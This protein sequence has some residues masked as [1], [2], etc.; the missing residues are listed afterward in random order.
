MRPSFSR[1]ALPLLFALSTAQAA[2]KA[3]LWPRWQAHDDSSTST[4][5]HSAWTAF[6]QK[7]VIKSSD[8]I[9]RVRYG[10]VTADDRKALEHYIETME[11][12]KIDQYS[13]ARQR[14]YWTNL[15]NAETLDLVLQHYPVKS[16]RDINLGGGLSG[17]VGGLFSRGPWDAKVL[18]VEGVALSLNDIE[19]RILRPIWKDPRTHYSVNCASLGCPNLRREAYTAENMEQ[20]LDAGARDYINNPRGARVTNGKLSVSSIYVWYQSDFGG[21][22]AGVIAHL[23]KYADAK[24]KKQLQ[25]ITS[26]SSNHYNWSLNAAG[27]E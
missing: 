10:A 21:N 12:V 13:R 17:F 14:P 2:P 22:D 15:Y 25:G 23:K 20:M 9:N 27:S 8:G 6:L 7:Y 3:D 16:I 26:I 18:K 19:H 24:L 4:I 11:A 1:L 5:D